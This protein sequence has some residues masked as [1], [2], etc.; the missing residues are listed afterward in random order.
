[1]W[2]AIEYDNCYLDEMLQM[3]VEQYGEEN[4]ISN[5]DFLTHQ[6]FENPTASA[7][8]YLAWDDEQSRIAGQYVVSPMRFRVEGQTQKCVNSLN[9][10]TRNAYR[11]R[12]IFTGLANAVYQYAEQEH[13]SFCYGMP[14]PNSYPG[15]I[16]KLSFTELGR[17]PLLLRPLKPSH[18]VK[19][20]LHSNLLSRPA[21]L[22]DGIFSAKMKNDDGVSIIDIDSDNVEL[23]DVL[24][25][26]VQDKYPIMNIRDSAYVKFRYLEM[27][28]REYHPVIAMKNGMPVAWAVGRI[29]EVA[30]MQCGMIADF[31][32]QSGEDAAAKILL[33]KLLVKLQENDACVAGSIMLSHTEEAKILKSKGFFKCP[34]KLEPQPFPLL[35]RI[36]DKTRADKKILQLSNWF[37]T[38]GDYDVI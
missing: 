24:W 27:P 29:M 33:D 30:G 21:G 31:L 6:Y 15:F 10:L 11:G 4:D 35:V 17:L 14:N 38:M 2:N 1:M 9:T 18:M 37:F 5:R 7:L 23:L 8:I 36:L 3:T 12:G 28:H 19:E 26:N 13:Y 32:F 34:R 25:E 22:F 20:F 16:K